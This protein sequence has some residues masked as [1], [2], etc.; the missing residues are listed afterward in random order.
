MLKRFFIGCALFVLILHVLPAQSIDLVLEKDGYR[1]LTSGAF[2]PLLSG[3]NPPAVG[4]HSF[5]PL[6]SG[7][8]LTAQYFH[9]NLPIEI[10]ISIYPASRPL[11]EE[12]DH[13]V[14]ELYAELNPLRP[15]AGLREKI[16]TAMEISGYAMDFGY[17]GDFRGERQAVA[18]RMEVYGSSRWF[19]R[20]RMTS[21]H[22]A[23]PAAAHMKSEL[24]E[25]MKWPKPARS[26]P[27]TWSPAYTVQFQGEEYRDI[28]WGHFLPLVRALQADTRLSAG[29]VEALLRYEARALRSRRLLLCSA[30]CADVIP[31]A[32]LA[33]LIEHEKEGTT[34]GE[35]SADSQA[36]FAAGA[37]SM[38]VGLGLL[39]YTL[40][41]D[42]GFPFPVLGMVNA[43]LMDAERK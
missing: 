41:A 34:L 37:A 42:P 14:S 29:T 22:D 5:P 8:E 28:W 36:V 20:L 31:I 12:F 43:D 18:R 21:A 39:F 16:S 3:F 2:F 32:A 13:A 11:E 33:Y 24:L 7:P 6:Y 25:R 1:H 26:L 30:I 38:F 10:C 9:K 35:W 23:A 17:T 40:K 27:I 4:Y 15:R 19:V